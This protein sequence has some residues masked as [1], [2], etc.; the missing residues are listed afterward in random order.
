MLPYFKRYAIISCIV[1]VAVPVVVSTAYAAITGKI[2]ASSIDGLIILLLLLFGTMMLMQLAFSRRVNAQVQDLLALY[3]DKCDPAAF[4]ERGRS[5]ADEITVPFNVDGSWFL[6]YY[7][8]ALLELGQADAA[9]QVLKD[10][11]E[12]ADRARKPGTRAGILL[13]EAVLAT[14]VEGPAAALRLMD[15]SYQ[16]FGGDAA[17]PHDRTVIFVKGQ[18]DLL[19]AE[20]DGDAAKQRALYVN[21][22]DDEGIPMRLRV[23][24]AWK[25]ARL[26]YQAGDIADERSELEFVVKHGNKLALVPQARKRLAEL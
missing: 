15:E 6:A 21:A 17:N 9:R 3:N 14:K 10:M 24:S 11:Q 18:R 13:N 8:Q 20:V 23:E 7:G 22:K 5:L 16:M 1:A 19:Q 26:D 4:V 25:L 12:S 2:M